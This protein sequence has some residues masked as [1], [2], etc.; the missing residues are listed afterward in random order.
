MPNTNLKEFRVLYNKLDDIISRGIKLDSRGSFIQKLNKYVKIHPSYDWLRDE[1][2]LIHDLRNVIVHEEKYKQDVAIPTATFLHKIKQIIMTLEQ[3]Q[4]ALDIAS[5]NV[6]HANLDDKL[7]DIVSVMAKKLYS[8]VP[9]FD[10]RKR[11]FTGVFSES[12]LMQLFSSKLESFEEG[13]K[14]TGVE[15][16]RDIRVFIEKPVRESWQFIS[17]DTDVYIIQR[18]FHSMTYENASQ[19]LS[20]LGVLFVTETGRCSDKLLGI[21]TA[22]D[23]SKIDQFGRSL[24]T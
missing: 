24:T 2:R 15:T 20:R 5:K 19:K 8:V 22:W 21:I 6:F 3:P 11:C 4:T 1:I 10:E 9:V 13:Y 23:L 18:M 14:P 16:M 17:K 12:V 7:V